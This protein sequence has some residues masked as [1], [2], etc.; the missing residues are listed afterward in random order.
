MN[1]IQTKTEDVHCQHIDQNSQEF[2]PRQLETH[3]WKD[4][5]R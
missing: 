1:T 4:E 5:S 3:P 2:Q